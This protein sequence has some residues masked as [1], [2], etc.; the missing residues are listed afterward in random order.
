MAKKG[1]SMW[2][3]IM[4]RKRYGISLDRARKMSLT[5]FANGPVLNKMTRDGVKAARKRKWRI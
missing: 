1:T 3:R 2:K 4:F 5:D